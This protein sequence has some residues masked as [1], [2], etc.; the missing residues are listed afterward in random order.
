MNSYIQAT[1]TVADLTGCPRPALVMIG[2]CDDEIPQLALR[3]GL[4]DAQPRA[5]HGRLDIRIVIDL[6]TEPEEEE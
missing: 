1:L 4:L 6:L 3:D 5:G 2:D